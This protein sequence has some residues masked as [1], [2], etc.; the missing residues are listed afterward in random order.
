ML[1]KTAIKILSN[2]SGNIFKKSNTC[3][4]TFFLE[5]MLVINGVKQKIYW[6]F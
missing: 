3:D 6:H 1:I 2:S 4:F 5:T